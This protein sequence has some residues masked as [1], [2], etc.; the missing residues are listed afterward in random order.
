M[1]GSLRGHRRQLAATVVAR[2]RA[3]DRHVVAARRLHALRVGAF[4]PDMLERCQRAVE[5]VLAHGVGRRMWRDDGRAGARLF[6]RDAGGQVF[7]SK[8]AHVRS[9]PVR[10]H[11]GIAATVRATA[12]RNI[13]VATLHDMRLRGVLRGNPHHDGL[14]LDSGCAS[15][16][17][18]LWFR[19]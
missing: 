10:R 15:L 2:A 8:P 14:L 12:G 7:E 11:D 5:A 6:G 16:A 19:Q 9:T 1:A 3:A 17:L 4:R 18:L 13:V